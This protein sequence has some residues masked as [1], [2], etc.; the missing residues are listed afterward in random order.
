MFKTPKT[1][2]SCH[3]QNHR[4]KMPPSCQALSFLS[5]LLLLSSPS[6]SLSSKTTIPTFSL[7]ILPLPSSRNPLPVLFCTSPKQQQEEAFLQFVAESKG[8][9]LP[10]VRTFE[11]DL[12]RL[13]LVGAVG[14]EQA[15][16]AAAADGGRA[17]AEHIDSGMPTMV[18][19][20]IFPGPGDEHATISTRLFL[21]AKKVKEKA[22]KFRS[23]YTEDIF[24]GTTS[25]NILAMTFRQV[26]LQQLWNFELVVLRPGTKRNME[27]LQNPREQ[28]PASFFLRS[29]KEEVIS[30][31]AEAV[32]IAALQDTE[33]HFLDDFL[34]KTSS[35]ISRWFQKPK[36]IVSKDSAVV[37]YKLFEDEIVENAKS[38]LANF[39][40]TKE[41]FRGIKK[42]NK[43]NWW[44]LVAHSKLEK[45]GGPD[46]SAWTSEY[47]PAYRLQINADK[48]K[49]VK[50]E[51]WRRSAENRWEVLL[52]HSQMA[53]LAEILDMYYED[54]YSLPDK[55]LSCHAI[56]KFTNFSNKKRSSSLLNILS[57]SLASGI[58]LITITALRQFSFPHIRK[59]EMY[60]QEHRSP[61][62]SEIKFAV[63]ESQDAEK[64]QGFCV[65]IVKKIKDAFGWPG[66]IITETDNG[67]WIGDVPKYLKVMGKSESTREENSTSAPEQKIDEDMKSS[68]Q[69]IASYQVVLSTDGKIV[70]FQPTSRVAVNH[71]ASNPLASELYG[72]RKLSPGFIEPSHK[73]RLPNEIVVIELLMSVNLNACFALARPVR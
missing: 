20:T 9:T 67:A 41:S 27:D 38:L 40:S 72:G 1:L 14:F 65:L 71:W 63:N 10:C 64:L 5:P 36:R 23:S 6:H 30:V 35:G 3:H 18:V 57:A 66:N 48:V 29:S 8:K 54:V 46:F 4:I 47:V 39:N 73:I 49:D 32:C 52:T 17:A 19:E 12:A 28:V 22:G 25:Q 44:T 56:T 55:E 43:Y 15:L 51:G 45:I 69:D 70:G 59:G 33:G 58:F 7:P 34:G 24:S 61:P 16:T 13:S 31:L 26:V 62:S 2:T 21:P 50:F 42:R 60:A 68:A 53:G 11:N 37:I